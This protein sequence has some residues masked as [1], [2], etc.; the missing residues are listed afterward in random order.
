MQ[1]KRIYPNVTY[2]KVLWGRSKEQQERGSARAALSRLKECV[3][4]GE[5]KGHT[6]FERGYDVCRSCSKRRSGIDGFDEG[7]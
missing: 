2:G 7:D 3:E 6:S 5:W 1:S 4:C